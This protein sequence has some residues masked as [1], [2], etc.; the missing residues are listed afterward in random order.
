MPDLDVKIMDEGDYWPARSVS[1]L[2]ENLDRMNG[3][4]AATAGA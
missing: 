2:R 1:K 4:V 3:L